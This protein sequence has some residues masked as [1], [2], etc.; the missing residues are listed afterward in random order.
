MKIVYAL[1][2]LFASAA[3]QGIEIVGGKEAAVGKHLYVTSLRAFT[4]G[5]AACTGSLIAPISAPKYAV[6]GSHFN[7]GNQDGELIAIKQQIV[8]PKYNDTSSAYNFAIYKLAKDSK[9]KPVPISFNPVGANVATVLRGFGDLDDKGNT[10][11][12]L[13]EVKLT[14]VDDTKCRQL[15]APSEVDNT[16][17]QRCVAGDGGGPLTIET[18]GQETLVGTLSWGDGCGQVNKPAVYNRL[19]VAR[20]FIQPYLTSKSRTPKKPSAVKTDLA[21][22]SAVTD[23]PTTTAPHN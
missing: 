22:A 23:A 4:D 7:G 14:T 19:N 17:Q 10:S 9:Y 5:L 15:L 12:V 6:V 2:A 3:A 11:P 1:T 16:I 20:D 21:D 18:N 8:H 13:R